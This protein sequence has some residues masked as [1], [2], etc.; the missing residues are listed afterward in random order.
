M[1]DAQSTTFGFKDSRHNEA[2][3]VAVDRGE[4][5][6]RNRKLRDSSPAG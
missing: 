5:S 3:G 6:S 4:L 2:Y 1:G